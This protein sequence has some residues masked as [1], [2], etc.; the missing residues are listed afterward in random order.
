MGL[1]LRPRRLLVIGELGKKGVRV[2]EDCSIA[3]Y[4]CIGPL[5][6]LPQVNSVSMPHEHIGASAL[7]RIINRIVYP[8]S[9]A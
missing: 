5:N 4:D 3:G 1:C 7:T 8:Y 9:P 6:G 2:P